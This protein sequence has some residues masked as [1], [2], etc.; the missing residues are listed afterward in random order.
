MNKVVIFTDSTS[1]LSLENRKKYGIEQF[2]LYVNFDEDQYRDGIDIT[3]TKLF[4]EV[5]LRKKLP[6][7][8][9]PTFA[10]IYTAFKKFIDDGYDIF[11]TGIGSGF[12][13]T[14][15]LVLQV[16]SEF[17][18]NRIYALDSKNLSS[19]VG[20]LAIEASKLRDEGK[21]AKE[22]YDILEVDREKLRCQFVIDS[23]DLAVS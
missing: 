7:S 1:D 16:A 11:Y 3:P 19:G 6:K 9:C 2:S 4:E 22:I 13:G 18:E 12:S 8:S 5:K 21:S 10:D 15:G 17:P 20:Y 23:L 14:L